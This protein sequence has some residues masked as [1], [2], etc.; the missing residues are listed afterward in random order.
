M[1]LLKSADFGEF[2]KTKDKGTGSIILTVTTKCY[3]G[4]IDIRKE[5]KGNSREYICFSENHR[6][7]SRID[8]I[9]ISKNLAS[10]IS[11]EIL[12]KTFPDHNPVSFD[13]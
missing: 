11:L 12:P 3:L 4:L 5:K 6:S 2:Y 9:Q 1:L 8:T 7:F 10:R 13:L